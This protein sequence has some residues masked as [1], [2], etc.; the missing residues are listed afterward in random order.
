MTMG[1]WAQALVLSGA[2][3]VLAACAS[4]D[5]MA[6]PT[7]GGYLPDAEARAASVDWSQARTLP[8]TLTE[9]RFEPSRLVFLQ[10]Q[11]YRL[12]LENRG[13]RT[14][15]FTAVRFFQS[16][17][18]WTLATWTPDGPQGTVRSPR[19]ETI[20]VAP[21]TAKDLLFLPVTVGQYPLTCSI[22]LHDTF[23]MTGAIAIV[24]ANG[25]G[26]GVS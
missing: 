23:G 15:T 5:V 12:H 19:L 1:A 24:P 4:G 22:L 18:P 13:S 8:V 3:V 25:V 11:P 17:A 20:E 2:L 26:G 14:H 9:Y 7:A 16:I 21:G 6:P 10:G